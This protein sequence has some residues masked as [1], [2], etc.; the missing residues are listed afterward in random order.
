MWIIPAFSFENIILDI[1]SIFNALEF[2]NNIWIMY[3]A[4][5]KIQ[6][7]KGSILPFSFYGQPLDY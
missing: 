3:I 6:E 7:P 2:I 5:A 4:L 1:T